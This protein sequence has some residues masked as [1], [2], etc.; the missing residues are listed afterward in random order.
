MLDANRVF[1]YQNKYNITY[2]VFWHTYWSRT[3]YDILAHVDEIGI[4]IIHFN[5]KLVFIQIKKINNNGCSFCKVLATIEPLFFLSWAKVKD[6][7]NNLQNRL[8][9]NCNIILQSDDKS[10]IFSSQKPRIIGRYILCLA[11]N[12]YIYIR[13]SLQET[14]YV[15]RLLSHL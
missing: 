11:N 14:P 2:N 9:N 4:S 8:N 12:I 5:E 3:F 7:W 15:Y 6:F 1:V 10:L 13:T